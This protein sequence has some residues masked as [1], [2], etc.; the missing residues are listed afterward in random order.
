MPERTVATRVRALAADGAAREL[1]QFGEQALKRLQ[2]SAPPARRGPAAA[3]PPLSGIRVSNGHL[4]S[5]AALNLEN[6]EE[7]ASLRA[8]TQTLVALN[9][10]LITELKR[11]TGRAA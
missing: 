6:L 7:T 11:V 10:A 9:A 1:R 4:E 2:D 8:L 3:S 5:I